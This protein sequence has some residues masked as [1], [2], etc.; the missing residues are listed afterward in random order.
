MTGIILENISKSFDGKMII[1]NL[2][3]EFPC[4]IV[5]L[6]GK[7]GCGKTTLARIIA[8]LE[9]PDNGK[10]TGVIG[11]VTYMFQ[12]PRLFPSFTA[13]ENVT[14][15][16][17]KDDLKAEAKELLLSLGL[18]EEDIN[19]LP[20]ELSGGMNQR[21]SLARA[22]LFSHHYGGN[23]V[24]LDE[25]FKGLDVITK[26]NAAQIVK[27][28]LNNKNVIIITHDSCDSVILSGACIS[29]EALNRTY[30]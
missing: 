30:R 5:C 21:V 1:E 2:S 15:I 22:L 13:L 14:S 19:K 24:I 26:E 11:N 4:G 7:S 3:A 23:T 6:S 16:A 28:W 18:T 20:S 25:P 8:G 9:K 27:K 29:F 12:E 10:I 17:Q